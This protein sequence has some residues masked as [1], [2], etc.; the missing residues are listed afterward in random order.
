MVTDGEGGQVDIS[1][2]FPLRQMSWIS[3]VCSIREQERNFRYM[4]RHGFKEIT[5]TFLGSTLR[6]GTGNVFVNEITEIIKGTEDIIDEEKRSKT[7]GRLV[8]Q[9]GLHF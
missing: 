5:E 6:T 3:R 7:I 1:A 4:V 8:G 2:Q 9:Y